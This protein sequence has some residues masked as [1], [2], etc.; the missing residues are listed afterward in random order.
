MVSSQISFRDFVM[1][2]F[3]RVGSTHFRNRTPW[4]NMLCFP[5]CER[6]LQV[7]QYS[8]LANVLCRVRMK[9]LAENVI[10]I[11]YC[12]LILRRHFPT[13]RRYRARDFHVHEHCTCLQKIGILVANMT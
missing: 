9:Y 6:E 7:P 4:F 5:G 1:L 8:D 3:C 12:M 2:A 13:T 11:P 10:L